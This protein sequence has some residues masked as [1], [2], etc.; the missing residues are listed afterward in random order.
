[1]LN[2]R[3]CPT[4][5]QS[6]AISSVPRFVAVAVSVSVFP[7]G[8]R[9]LWQPRSDGGDIWQQDPALDELISG[10]THRDLTVKAWK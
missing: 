1:M 7:N 5:I 10:G 8:G 9:Q 2:S 4:V 6:G 3:W